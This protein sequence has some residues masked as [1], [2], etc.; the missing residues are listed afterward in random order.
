MQRDF[1]FDDDSWAAPADIK[2]IAWAQL[3]AD[4][5]PA[6]VFQAAQRLWPLISF[7][8]DDDA[9]GVLDDVDNCPHRYNPGQEDADGDGVGDI[10]D[11]CETG[12]NP[13]QLDE[14]EDGFGDACDNC[15]VLHHVNQDDT[16]G[17][18]VG[19]VCDS[20]PEVDSPGGVDQFGRALGT[21]DID[22]DVDADDF[23]LFERCMAGPD[24]T[25]PPPECELEHFDR[26]DLDDDGDVDLADLD[27]FTLNF[28]G[29]LVSPPMYVG[30]ASCAE[31]HQDRHAE[32]SQTIHATAFDT[33][34]ES[35][36]GD[37]Y[38]C[39]PC[40]SVGYGQPS[41][42]VDLETTPE[43]ADV[44]CENCHGPGSNHNADP[45]NV[46]LAINYDSNLCGACHQ[47]CHGLCGENHHPQFEQ[48]SISKH[49]TAMFDIVW[50][51]DFED[52]CL[53]C[54]SA[55]YRFAPEDDKPTGAEVLFNVECV[56]C[57]TGHNNVNAGQ[58]RMPAY[59]LCADCHTMGDVVPPE[60]PDQPQAEVLHG[61]GGYELDGSPMAGPHTAHWWG[62]PNECAVC[63]VHEA[64]YGGP[65]EPVDSGH[66]FLA[67]MRA[68]EPCHSEEAAT[69]LVTMMH[70]EIEVRLAIIAH[71]FDPDDP[72]YV[73]PDG[74]SPEERARYD[75]A[76]FNYE[77]VIADNSFGSHNPDYARAL[78]A[79]TEEFFDIPP[80]SFLLL[81]DD[82]GGFHHGWPTGLN[83]AEMRP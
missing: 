74:L 54:H 80:W 44:Q 3:P 29:P 20:C 65:E 26:A 52:E 39:F 47:S 5:G 4:S 53:Q 79:E 19:D 11:N 55:D 64:P 40:H 21:I 34:V 57:H 73:D 9:D 10:C 59:E 23:A 51:P 33:L 8:N 48:W 70:E 37:N 12:Y 14:D 31:C 6:Y 25:T 78:L 2:I 60:F 81:P 66:D 83:Q 71:Y 13:D 56:V 82:G 67:D 61:F 18:G 69:L 7:P 42:F 35:G 63:H 22:C 27:V 41:G 43:L 1:T 15:P 45:N 58:L 16:D 49:A 24:I 76:R 75:I 17:D 38:L 72:L 32:W 50:D 77:L 62:L 36:D 68:C 30:A 28:T 46:H